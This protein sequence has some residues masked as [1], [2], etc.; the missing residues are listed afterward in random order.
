MR[1]CRA[2]KIKHIINALEAANIANNKK[3]VAKNCYTKQKAF[4]SADVFFQLVFMS[5]TDFNKIANLTG[6]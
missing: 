5:D 3:L 2:L 4:N 1:K 6:V